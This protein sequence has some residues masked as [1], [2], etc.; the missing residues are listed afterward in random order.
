MHALAQAEQ[1]VLVATDCLSEGINLQSAF[2]AVIH[3]DL[4]WNPTRHEQREGRVDRYGQPRERVKVTTMYGLDN[5]IDGIV[6][7]VLIKKHKTIRSSLGISVPVPAQSDQVVEAIF[8]GLLLRGLDR[9]SNQQQA[10]FEN[11]DEYV[12]PRAADFERLWDAAAARERRSRTMFAQESLKVDDVLRELTATRDALGTHDLVKR[13]LTRV[14]PAH[15]G[16]ITS[17]PTGALELDLSLA[18]A[19]LTDALAATRLRIRFEEPLGANETLVARTSPL[20]ETLASYVLDTALD[21]H[22]DGAARR[23]GVMLTTAVATRTTL[24]LTRFRYHLT[25]I[26]GDDSWQTLAEDVVP[27]AFTGAPGAAQ[28]L[29]PDRANALLDAAPGGNIDPGQAHHMFERFLEGV[30]ALT[31]HLESVA[32][33]RAEA[34]LDAHRRVRSAA[35]IKGLRYQVAP[36]LPAD[37]LG[38]YLYLPG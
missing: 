22:L 21:P 32:N 13:F 14:A 5:Q 18:P 2:D 23:A 24:L 28:W 29:D 26:R 4:S 10:L 19:A 25:T 17:T 36:L 11:L 9:R 34:L 33:D 3:Y 27:L 7:D 30:A 38:A 15:N 37:I 16:T 35:R 1:R 31:P 6:L 8:E 12:K 20:T